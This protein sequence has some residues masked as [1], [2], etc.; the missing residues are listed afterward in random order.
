MPI[1]DPNVRSH[2]P[3]SHRAAVTPEIADNQTLKQQAQLPGEESTWQMRA[4]SSL[5]PLT[6]SSKSS[7]REWRWRSERQGDG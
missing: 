3:S 6:S 5:G 7:Q 1:S 4:C 2:L